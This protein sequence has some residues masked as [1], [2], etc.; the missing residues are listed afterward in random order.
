[1]ANEIMIIDVEVKEKESKVKF[2]N[3]LKMADKCAKNIQKVFTTIGPTINSSISHTV[4]GI[5]AVLI[6]TKNVLVSLSKSVLG[7]LGANQDIIGLI[8]NINQYVN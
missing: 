8:N 4:S 6:G 5:S 7:Y 1:M 3:L 2:E